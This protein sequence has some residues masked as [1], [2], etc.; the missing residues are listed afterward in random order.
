MKTRLRILASV[1]L[2]AALRPAPGFGDNVYAARRDRLRSRIVGQAVLY[3]GLN[4][5]NGLDK[6][7][8]YLSGLAVPDAFLIL[9]GRTGLDALF[10]DF[11]KAR[12]SPADIIRTSG[13]ASLYFRD[14]A[15]TALA[16]RLGFDPRV[17]F[18]MAYWPSDPEYVYPDCLEIERLLS[19]FFYV[20]KNSLAPFLYPLR[21]VKD[22]GE[23]ALIE[24]AVGITG[25]GALAG[26]AALKPGRYESEIQKVIED[27]FKALGA[28]RTSFPSI[29]GSGPNSLILHYS[30]NSRRMEAGEVVVMDVGAEYG[31][32]AGDITRTAPVSGRFTPRQLQVYE[33]V[34]EMQRRVVAACRPGVTCGQLNDAARAYATEKGFGAY[35]NYSGWHHGTDHSLGLDVHD[36]FYSSWPLTAGMVITVEPGIYLPAENLGVRLE[37]D[38]LI[39][40]AGAVVL[41]A[42]VPREAAEIEAVMAGAYKAGKGRAVK[43]FAGSMR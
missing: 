18:P 16:A 3:S 27:T 42:D 23:I 8:Y 11:L 38:V 29:V 10:I 25:A 15:G 1:V 13:I 33:V 31:R 41:T 22:A 24:R 21:M 43:R 39:T 17:F 36:P 4:E 2:I 9:D 7:F 14:Q 28:P 6:S 5:T 40:A 32:Y 20:Q 34:L 37:D 35:F 30:E 26:I 19:G 12:M